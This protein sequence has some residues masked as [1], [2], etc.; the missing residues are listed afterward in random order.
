MPVVLWWLTGQ[1]GRGGHSVISVPEMEKYLKSG[2]V[3]VGLL[4]QSVLSSVAN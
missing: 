1:R 4:L 2:M 3:R